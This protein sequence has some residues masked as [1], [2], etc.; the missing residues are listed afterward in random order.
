MSTHSPD[1]LFTATAIGDAQL[2]NRVALAPMT[3]VSATEG[4]IPT[5][6]ISDYYGVFAEGGFGLLITE[7]LYIDQNASQG[8]PFQPG[9]AT[10]GQS[11]AWT[12]IVDRVHNAGSKIVAQL[13]HAG[14]QAQANP[15]SDH[16]FGPST[17]RAKGEQMSMYR[18]SGPYRVPTAMTLDDIA[19][20]RRAFVTAARHA[21]DAGFDGVELHGANG[22]LIDNFLTDYLNTRTD[23][24]GGSV[25]NRVRL[26]AEI[27]ADVVA[28]VGADISVGIR[29]SQAKVSDYDHKWA[30]GEEEAAT[31]FGALGQAGIDFVHTTEYRALAP[32]FGNDGKTLAAF[33]KEYAR[34]AV[35]VNGNL[36]D[37]ADA[38]SI[39]ESGAADIVALGKAALANRNWPHKVAL[40]HPLDGDIPSD[41]LGPIAT[42]K[43][44]ETTIP[45][46]PSRAG[47]G[48][49][50]RR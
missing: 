19:E 36:D 37:P 1:A 29:I 23:Q 49:S 10:S 24:Y 17:V 32:A 33:A 35:I 11:A 13:Q 5:G 3:R 42:I 47:V 4:G 16:S 22:Y 26:A 7:G 44:W 21:R 41:V 43:D 46:A 9:M 45:A 31:I 25:E 8:Y 12:P 40:G 6:R 20:V 15:Y 2:A 30:G 48:A 50:V 18:G 38:A 39:V 14:V 28:D 34:T 27:C